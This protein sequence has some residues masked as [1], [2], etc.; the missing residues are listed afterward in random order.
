M[1]LHEPSCIH[2]GTSGRGDPIHLT[3]ICVSVINPS[4]GKSLSGSCGCFTLEPLEPLGGKLKAY[5]IPHLSI[6]GLYSTMI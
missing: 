2:V 4:G 3:R 1:C 5:Q 6:L